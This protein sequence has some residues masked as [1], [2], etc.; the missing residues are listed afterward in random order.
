MTAFIV[1]KKMLVTEAVTI[2]FVKQKAFDRLRRHLPRGVS[3]CQHA[4][5]R[6][7]QLCTVAFVNLA[8]QEEAAKV[9]K[10]DA[11]V[12]LRVSA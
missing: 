5:R 11:C 12:Y 1:L 9:L 4:V 7:T 8:D 2:T 10:D 3:V 6:E